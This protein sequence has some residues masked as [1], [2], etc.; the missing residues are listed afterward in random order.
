MFL[1]AC[2][3]VMLSIGIALFVLVY[4]RPP[5]TPPELGLVGDRDVNLR[6][7]PGRNEKIVR[8]LQR[9]SSVFLLEKPDVKLGRSVWIAV[10]VDGAQGW[11]TIA[12]VRNAAE[13]SR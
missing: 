4:E 2:V 6:A 10:Q 5:L 13:V 9:G 12:L 3:F 7:N 1:C 8:V 11:V